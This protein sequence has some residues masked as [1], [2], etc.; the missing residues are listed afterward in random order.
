[1]T[2]AQWRRFFR[3]SA[4]DQ[5]GS[6]VISAGDVLLIFRSPLVGLCLLLWYIL[7]IPLPCYVCFV[8]VFVP[9]L[10][11]PEFMLRG[12]RAQKGGG[13]RVEGAN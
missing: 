12:G 2:Q 4:W 8:F 10:S 6:P 13:R 9:P 5:V 1:M 3:A 7:S 11:V